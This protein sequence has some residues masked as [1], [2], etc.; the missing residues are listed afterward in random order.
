MSIGNSLYYLGLRLRPLAKPIVWCPALVVTLMGI[1]LWQYRVNP[2]WSGQFDVEGST[3]GTGTLLPEGE[4]LTDAET[5]GATSEELDSGR[6]G[7]MGFLEDLGL[8]GT[9]SSEEVAGTEPEDQVVVDSLLSLLTD[10]ES[11]SE[12]GAEEGLN[13]QLSGRR[14][15]F[16]EYI[17]AY[18]LPGAVTPS[19]P[20]SSTSPGGLGDLSSI[21]N[22]LNPP[23]S[24]QD[25]LSSNT[26]GNAGSTG[27][28]PLER[29]L[30]RRTETEANGS[31]DRDAAIEGEAS[32]EE[33]Q[34][35]NVAQGTAPNQAVVRGNIPGQPFT[36]IR[37]TPQMSP[38][39]GTT[40][41]TPPAS[42]DFTPPAQST[43]GPAVPSGV[44]GG[45]SSFQF[46]PTPSNGSVTPSLPNPNG[47]N[48]FAQPP[49]FNTVPPFS[50]PRPNSQYL[51]N[52]QIQTFSNPLGST[53]WEPSDYIYRR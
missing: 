45:R 46:Q 21:L 11:A 48:S 36:F 43:G 39:P 14:D 25:A 44:S 10:P 22:L 18:S 42:L 29:S 52:G 49:Q 1:L 17:E 15:P 41:Y 53:G 30:N 4:V 31:L 32:G 23:S 7:F 8:L 16:A 6:S 5:I 19:S 24:Q 12:E 28:T 13:R 50:A 20:R 51:G 3:P 40:G 26:P 37:T 33:G 35:A 47:V 38:P 2:E 34:S 9:P 27:V